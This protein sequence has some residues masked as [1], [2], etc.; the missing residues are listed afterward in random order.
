MRLR[1]CCKGL[2]PQLKVKGKG[3]FRAQTKAPYI[4]SEDLRREHLEPKRIQMVHS[5]AHSPAT[6]VLIEAVKGG[7]EQLVVE[8]PLIIYKEEGE[9]TDELLRLYGKLD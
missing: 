9:Y 3:I 7:G 8:S 1:R 2:L 4:Y 6:L 5:F